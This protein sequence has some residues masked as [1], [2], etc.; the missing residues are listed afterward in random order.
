MSEYPDE[1][2]I[3]LATDAVSSVG[4]A[5]FFASLL[6]VIS[7]GANPDQQIAM[8]YHPY[9]VPEIR[10]HKGISKIY[11]N[12]YLQRGFYRHDPVYH[13]WRDY[14]TL[15]ALRVADVTT[16]ELSEAP[17]M[18]EFIER[19]GLTDESGMLLPWLAG[20]C[21]GLFIGMRGGK[22]AQDHNRFL[23]QIFPFLQALTKAHLSK[24]LN[25]LFVDTG[26]TLDSRRAMMIQD[27]FENV[28]FKS[29]SWTK[30]EQDYPILID[31]IKEREFISEGQAMLSNSLVLHAN[32]VGRSPDFSSV[33][34]VFVVER[35]DGISFSEANQKKRIKKLFFG[36]LTRREQEVVELM[37]KGFPVVLI[38]KE[39][40]I[41]PG[42]V[43]NHKTKI[44][45]K[46]DVTTE[47]E[48]FSQL[49]Y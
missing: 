11:M 2:F 46:L 31:L 21:V 16:P 3:N 44:Y 28:I 7:F 35:L 26:A 24:E 32:K 29:K 27:E 45:Y 19:S 20:S 47:R 34:N 38:A 39:L 25:R 33:N 36:N 18:N 14:G 8:R 6:N 17:Y 40:G 22:F 4:T 13:Y 49:L 5:D 10:V 41:S 12:L 48:L 15:G 30:L 9:S 23:N 43:K 42:T 1:N 37:L